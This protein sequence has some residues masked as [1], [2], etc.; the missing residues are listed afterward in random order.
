MGSRFKGLPSPV[1]RDARRAH[2]KKN[3]TAGSTPGRQK[4]RRCQAK[5]R[6][7]ILARTSRSYKRRDYE[8]WHEEKRRLRREQ[9]QK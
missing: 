3:A 6:D 7:R 9:G 8:Q 2:R 1:R 5:A 4:V